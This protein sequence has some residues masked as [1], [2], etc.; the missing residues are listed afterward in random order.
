MKP[1]GTSYDTSYKKFLPDVRGSYRF[2]APLRNWF[3][4]ESYAEVIFKPK[5][6]EDL[7]YFLKNFKE[8]KD[9]KIIGATSNILFK[10]KVTNGVIIKLSNAFTTISHQGNIIEIGTA[11]LC[12]NAAKYGI[13]NSLS[14]LEFMTGVPGSIGGALAMNAGCYGSETS[15]FLVSAK[16]VD[17]DGNIL[18]FKN[19]D[20]GFYYRGNKLCKTQQGN[21][22]FTSA[23][24]QCLKK[25]PRIIS[26]KIAEFE[27]KREESQ[28]IR[29]KTGGST[30]KNPPN[31][32][33]WQLIDEAGCRGLKYNDAQ[34]SKKHCN[35]LVNTGNATGQD[36]ITLI[37]QVQ[38]KVKKEFN[39]D[40]ETEIKII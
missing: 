6:I 9:I 36:I 10:D 7:S 18:N 29:A 20:F 28:P 37:K 19:E 15:D 12:K 23:Q 33:A 27:K 2:N 8:K 1:N 22:I 17:L 39:I 35:F 40:L 32:K 13:L 16:A 31:H 30:F 26:N 21:L 38:G 34:I 24:F 14:N 11:T 4:T 5:D 25:E 3:N